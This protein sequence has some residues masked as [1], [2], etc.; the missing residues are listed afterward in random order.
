MAS[1]S[2]KSE[3]QRHVLTDQLRT[4]DQGVFLAAHCLMTEHEFAQSI[5]DSRWDHYV[6]GL[7]LD[8]GAV[9]YVGKG[10]KDRA[11]D[12]A[13]SACH[14]DDSE[15]AQ[16]IRFIGEKLRYT[17][18]FQCSDDA[19]AKGYEAYLIRGHSDV[20]ANIAIPSLAAIDKMLEPI[21]PQ[22]RDRATLQYVAELTQKAEKELR[23][24]LLRIIAGCPPVMQ[25]ISYEE[26]AWATGMESGAEARAAIHMRLV[27][28]EACDGC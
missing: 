8:N 17:L 19:Y 1:Q 22:E 12:H 20:L 24:D 28:D 9:F 16:Y 14:G 21:D 13:K 15:K 18:F 5:K 2:R 27:A 10:V 4:W 11:L 23:R 7:C 6:Y 26:L 3:T 25:T